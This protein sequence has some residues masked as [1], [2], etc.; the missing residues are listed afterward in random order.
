MDQ[1]SKIFVLLLVASL[2][3]GALVVITNPDYRPEKILKSN[4]HY[5]PEFKPAPVVAPPASAAEPSR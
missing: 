4:E 1:A 3:A 5:Y 2:I